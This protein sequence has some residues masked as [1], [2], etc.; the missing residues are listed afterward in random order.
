M[1][2]DIMNNN[3]IDICISPSIGHSHT[4]LKFF[5]YFDIRTMLRKYSRFLRHFTNEFTSIT[6]MVRKDKLTYHISVD[7]IIM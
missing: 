6:H 2:S 1:I 7:A 4:S 3:F 5:S